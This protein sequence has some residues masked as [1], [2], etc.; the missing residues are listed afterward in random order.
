M[1]LNEEYADDL[2][3]TKENVKIQFTEENVKVLLRL[4]AGVSDRG[5][6][7][8]FDYHLRTVHDEGENTINMQT[9]EELLAIP[10]GSSEKSMTAMA[11]ME[12]L[13]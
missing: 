8:A 10:R 11:E 5:N 13:Y 6:F 12:K 4:A 9:V 3:V 1:I 7:D 2:K